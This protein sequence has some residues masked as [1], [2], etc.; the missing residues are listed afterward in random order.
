LYKALPSN[1]IN[2]LNKCVH[3]RNNSG[4]SRN[5][6]NSGNNSRKASGLETN[7]KR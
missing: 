7:F 1:F 5:S 4:N 2:I 3:G 6:R